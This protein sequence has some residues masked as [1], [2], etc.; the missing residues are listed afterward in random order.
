MKH[1]IL[2]TLLVVACFW[3]IAGEDAPPE[4]NLKGEVA[5][6]ISG[7]KPNAFKPHPSW[8]GGTRAKNYGV[9]TSTHGGL[10]FSAQDGEMKWSVPVKNVSLDEYPYLV[11]SYR[12]ENFNNAP[13]NDFFIHLDT[14][15]ARRDWAVR[16]SEIIPD[17]KWRTMVIE[18]PPRCGTGTVHQ[19]VIHLVN[20]RK[21]SVSLEIGDL[22]FASEP[23][24]G[25]NVKLRPEAKLLS[26]CVLDS[27]IRIG[28]RSADEVT[29]P[30]GDSSASWQRLDGR[31][32]RFSVPA[33][34][35]AARWNLIFRDPIKFKGGEIVEIVY[36]ARNMVE[37]PN[38]VIWL[39]WDVVNDTIPVDL[40]PVNLDRFRADGLRRIAVGAVPSG[41]KS[42]WSM[43][44]LVRSSSAGKSELEIEE[45]RVYDAMPSKRLGELLPFTESSGFKNF[46][47]PVT[48]PKKNFNHQV[49]RHSFRPDSY[50]TVDQIEIESIPFRISHSDSLPDLT[51]TGMREYDAIEIP[52]HGEAPSEIYFL[53]GIRFSGNNSP[54]IARGKLTAIAEPERFVIELTGVDGAVERIFPVNVRS[55]RHVVESGMDLYAIRPATVRKLAK[56]TLR[57]NMTNGAFYLAGAT[58]NTGAPKL[59]ADIH[60]EKGVYTSMPAISIPPSPATVNIKRLEIVSE[61]YRL[62]LDPADPLRIAEF[63][64]LL[65]G[66]NVL[67]GSSKNHLLRL[68]EDIHAGKAEAIKNGF[69]I[70]F[71]GKF[72]RGN[73][74]VT[75]DPYAN[76]VLCRA[77]AEYIGHEKKMVDASFPSFNDV[78]LA[79]DAWWFFP[80][81]GFTA[82]S[83]FVSLTGRYGGVFPFQIMGFFSPK[84]RGGFYLM[85]QDTQNSPRDFKLARGQNTGSLSILSCET[86][87]LPGEKLK[88]APFAF[89]VTRGD[90][91]SQAK[92]YR[93]WLRKNFHTRPA[94]AWLQDRF[95]LWEICAHHNYYVIYDAA[96]KRFTYDESMKRMRDAL[97]NAD[98]LHFFDFGLTP[99]H[100]RVGDYDDFSLLGGEDALKAFIA[101]ALKDGM[102]TSIYVEGN[103]ASRR[104]RWISQNGNSGQRRNRAGTPLTYPGSKDELFLCPEF[105][106][107]QQHLNSLAQRLPVETG[108]RAFYLD[109]F[110]YCGPDRTCFAEGHGHAIPGYPNVGEGQI[111][112][113][114][115][116]TLPD[117]AILTEASPNDH[118]LQFQDGSLSSALPDYREDANPARVDLYRYFFPEF[119]SF[120]LLALHH[121]I[122]DGYMPFKWALFNAS[123]MMISGDPALDFSEK[124]KMFFRDMNRIIDINRRYFASSRVEVDLPGTASGI[125]ANRFDVANGAMITLLNG[126]Y[127]SVS[128]ELIRLALPPGTRARDWH[129][130]E[131][132]L[133]PLQEK[134]MF[135]IIGNI[136]PRDVTGIILDFGEKP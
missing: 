3:T 20:L 54:A 134:N 50:F 22:G 115:S 130:R 63:T 35:A 74:E 93:N 83:S 118:N 68:P 52:M 16:R 119:K 116:E 76:Q 65:T 101:R 73:I 128:G 92:I 97:G 125:H 2:T 28:Q 18:L 105:K 103:L 77:Q 33:A 61:S 39:G 66:E 99:R 70:P 36:R 113:K 21:R 27:S 124:G 45:I 79:D 114:I 38:G 6:R 72:F 86:T 31:G 57:D 55:G 29:W 129:G 42:A 95:L 11:F 10:L 131:C 37:N 98:M 53:L 40:R 82:G 75:A 80:K 69:R 127:R 17:G 14:D 88:L 71:D 96:Q 49:L 30:R 85:G 133:R 58:L 78:T 106:P 44:V 15:T 51:G 132:P 5:W 46:F 60:M 7:A 24:R 109:E 87:L 120:Q 112:R 111:L 107:W 89:G 12:T 117:C 26:R 43:G 19:V 135:A 122:G 81:L 90:W 47:R 23:P 123:G 9:T 56:I 104:S 94:K 1:K 64:N 4:I 34:N 41:L 48:L 8:V 121:V 102:P 100:G 136:A 108:A 25:D 110:G 84:K 32:I 62:R 67:S 126:N 13:G 59:S 91:K